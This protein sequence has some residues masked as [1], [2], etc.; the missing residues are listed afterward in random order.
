[1]DKF[2]NI[3]LKNV[4]WFSEK[5]NT[6]HIDM[7][8]SYQRNAVWT[9][10]QKSYLIDSILNGYPIPEIYVQEVVDEMGNSN[11]IIVDGQQRMRAVLEFLNN[12][13]ALNKDDSPQF[14]GAYFKD[15]D[16]EYKRILFKYNFVVRTLPELPEEEI[17]EIFKR[18]NQN[19]VKLNN[20]ELRK[21]AYSGRLL[22]IVNDISEFPLWSELRIFTSNDIKRM[23]DEEYISE[24]ILAAVEGITNKKDRLESFYEE[25]ETYFPY[26]E[27]INNTFSYISDVLLPIANDLSK[28]RWRN[29]TDFYS[30]FVAL[31]RKQGSFAISKEIITKLREKL[32]EISTLVYECLDVNEEHLDKFAPEIKDYTKGVR[33]ASDSTARTLRQGA[34]DAMLNEV[35]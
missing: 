5:S 3:S 22:S 15:L 26:E 34:L 2:L 29:K 9:V 12:E 4:A 11:C 7:T 28:T 25:S 8:P 35:F 13:F 6:G 24:L 10:K 17:R 32:M 23:K 1:M 30:L 16:G 14:E 27:Q 33:A 19:V 21:A 31:C 18:L 20:Q